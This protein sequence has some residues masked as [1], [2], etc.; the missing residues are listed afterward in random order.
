MIQF[1]L[2]LVAFLAMEIVAWFMHKYVMH[3][4]LWSL[5]KDHHSP[6][7]KK[8][9]KNDFFALFFAIP[10]IILI[11]LGV[12]NGLD[13]R[14]WIGIGIT[15]YGISYFLFHDILFH[16][17]ISLLKQNKNAYFRAVVKAHG[18]HHSGKKNYGFLFMFPWKYFKETK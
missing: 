8:L 18:D 5:H 9:E 13:Y 6:V 1:L 4:F 10:S 3:G 15:L 11:Y 14:F 16:Q 12:A 2:V 7:K 17:R